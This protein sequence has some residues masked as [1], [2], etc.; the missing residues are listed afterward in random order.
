MFYI[1][2][3]FKK[4]EINKLHALGPSGSNHLVNQFLQEGPDQHPCAIVPIATQM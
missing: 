1:F 2:L 4:N 3:I